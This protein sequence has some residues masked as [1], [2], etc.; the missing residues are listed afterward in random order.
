MDGEAAP[1]DGGSGKDS[2][3]W[4]AIVGYGSLLSETSARITCPS[5]RNFQPVSV[6]GYRRVYN[7]VSISNIKRG[8]HDWKTKQVAAVVAQP[9][10]QRKMN[11]NNQ[12]VNSSGDGSPPPMLASYFEIPRSELAGY[13]LREARYSFEEATV[14]RWDHGGGEP[15][16]SKSHVDSKSSASPAGPT[17]TKTT[18][19]P[20]QPKAIICTE[21][22]G[23]DQEAYF[24]E[25][26]H[27]DKA[28][29]NADIG[30]YYEGPLWRKDILPVDRYLQLCLKGA[31]EIAGEKGV[32]NFVA[33]SYLADE[34]TTLKD[35]LEKTKGTAA[36]D[37]R[38]VDVNEAAKAA[39]AIIN[40]QSKK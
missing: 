2:K 39:A 36:F 23:G 7:L 14:Q 34:T 15:G 40:D 6:A 35:Y 1:S 32:E 13:Y 33:T 22:K 8:F 10:P 12:D 29:Y 38:A 4:V 18:L 17:A 25:V 5:L 9:V 3:D 21:Y 19:L 28:K 27:G 30:K 16:S 31:F 20:L 11:A 26:Y 37:P 24:K